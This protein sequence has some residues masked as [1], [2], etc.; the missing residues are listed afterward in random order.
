[1]G[2][3][4]VKLCCLVVAAASLAM[5]AWAIPHYFIGRVLENTAAMDPVAGANVGVYFF[6]DNFGTEQFRF[7]GGFLN[8][9]TDANGLF[10]VLGDPEDLE[11]SR[12]NAK[13]VVG[14]TLN[15]NTGHQTRVKVETKSVDL[16]PNLAGIFASLGFDPSLSDAALAILSGLSGVDI[17]VI[18]TTQFVAI[19][20]AGVIKVDVVPAPPAALL[21]GTALLGFGALS[22]KAF[23]ARRPRAALVG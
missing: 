16:Q 2:K 22:R 9:V 14:P 23:T 15:A 11:I 18:L 3:N 7:P 13:I 6:Q 8:A 10:V 17:P 1:M 21:L 5:P 20:G 4:F 12:E 19:G